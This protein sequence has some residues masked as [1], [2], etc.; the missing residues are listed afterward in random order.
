MELLFDPSSPQ[1]VHE[2]YRGP[3]G[4][5]GRVLYVAVRPVALTDAPVED[6]EGLLNAIFRL[7]N[8]RWVPTSFQDNLTLEWSTKGFDPL[9]IDNLTNQ[10]LNVFTVSESDPRIRP[11][12]KIALNRN[13]TLFDDPAAVFRFDVLVRGAGC[14]PATISLRVQLGPTWKD[15]S[16]KQI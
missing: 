4:E 16:V 6:C 10:V 5:G 13:A 2:T 3:S 9:R 14:P 15:I 12:G 1:F 11:A 7:E 8:E